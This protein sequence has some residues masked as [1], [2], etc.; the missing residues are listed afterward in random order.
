[1]IADQRS[2]RQV[3]VNQLDRWCPHQVERRELFLLDRR[4]VRQPL[5]LQAVQLRLEVKLSGRGVSSFRTCGVRH[6]LVM[7]PRLADVALYRFCGRHGLLVEQEE[8]YHVFHVQRQATSGSIR[9]GRTKNIH[10][11]LQAPLDLI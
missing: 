3:A 4:F 11:S 7:H 10:E 6:E 1:M 5:A 8:V 9:Q 2:I